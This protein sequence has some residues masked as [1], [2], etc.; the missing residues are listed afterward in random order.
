MDSARPPGSR[1]QIWQREEKY[2]NMNTGWWLPGERACSSSLRHRQLPR[3]EERYSLFSKKSGDLGRKPSC[4]QL[5]TGFPPQTREP[6]SFLLQP[7]DL[8]TH[9][10][11]WRPVPSIL[12]GPLR[13]RAGYSRTM[14]SGPD[15]CSQSWPGLGQHGRGFT[16]R[17]AWAGET[18]LLGGAKRSVC[19]SANIPATWLGLCPRMDV[20]DDGGGSSFELQ[21][22]EVHASQLKPATLQGWQTLLFYEADDAGSM[23]LSWS[24]GVETS[25]IVS[26]SVQMRLQEVG[27]GTGTL[28]S[29]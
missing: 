9:G 29:H 19:A 7:S 1:T 25:T 15:S 27:S 12:Q 3:N 11:Q 17:N 13:L 14:A 22:K 4:L 10:C 26:Y 28:G 16:T 5:V 18:A 2:L 24:H 23:S 8:K 20:P 6:F 21:C